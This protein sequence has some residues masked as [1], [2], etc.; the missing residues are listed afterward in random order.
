MLVKLPQINALVVDLV[1]SLFRFTSGD[2]VA[3]DLA[4][5]LG[6]VFEIVDERVFKN[7]LNNIAGKVDDVFKGGTFDLLGGKFVAWSNLGGCGVKSV[8][9][10]AK[11]FAELANKDLAKAI[12]EISTF[13]IRQTRDATILEWGIGNAPK[14]A[15]PIIS[16]Y[17]YVEGARTWPA[18]QYSAKGTGAKLAVL[19]GYRREIRM[20][21][22]VIGAVALGFAATYIHGS[23]R[24]GRIRL[25]VPL[26]MVEYDASSLDTRGGAI[27]L[28][29]RVGNCGGD[30][31][32]EHL[33]RLVVASAIGRP[34]VVKLVDLAYSGGV[35]VGRDSSY[36]LTI[37]S[38]K[39]GP[40]LHSAI[41]V[42][43]VPGALASIAE[44]W[45]R[46]R[47]RRL[48]EDVCR[49]VNQLVD[50]TKHIYLLAETGYVNEAYEAL[51]TL[52]RLIPQLNRV[53]NGDRLARSA[54][55]MA[56]LVEEVLSHVA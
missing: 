38:T 22:N 24:Q 23:P 54:E 30:L 1:A 14:Y 48:S 19:Q 8:Q 4:E 2:T 56:R 10:L 11:N 31:P 43:G 44:Y 27:R 33:L 25:L 46:C 49:L 6:M 55:T 28:L 34:V 13:N 3:K 52:T 32:P 51:T 9:D 7:K 39:L 18:Q 42:R 37:D 36:E 45:C 35:E 12:A 50:A 20:S 5:G 17:E 16:G 41:R 47:E 40:L 29:N 21:C 15:P 53:E 26:S